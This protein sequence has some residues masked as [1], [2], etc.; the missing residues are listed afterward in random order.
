MNRLVFFKRVQRKMRT[1]VA[2]QLARNFIVR[3]RIL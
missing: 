2:V 1:S 3:L